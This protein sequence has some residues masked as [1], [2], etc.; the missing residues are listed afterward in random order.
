MCVLFHFLC[1]VIKIAK[2]EGFGLTDS[3]DL[4]PHKRVKC[5]CC[6]TITKYHTKYKIPNPTQKHITDIH[7]QTSDMACQHLFWSANVLAICLVVLK[8]ALL[9]VALAKSWVQ[10]GVL[11]SS[12]EIPFL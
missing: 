4:N 7:V 5:C 8:R 9:L 11:E 3:F 10:R 2:E 12:H 1:G 6:N